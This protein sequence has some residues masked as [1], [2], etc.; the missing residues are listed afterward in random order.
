MSVYITSLGAFLPGNP[1]SNEEMEEYLGKIHGISSRSRERILKQN[2]IKT[3]YYAIDKT[4]TS[5]FSNSQMAANAATQA[6]ARSALLKEDVEL[7]VAATSQGDHPLPGFASMI[8]GELKIPRCEIA[9]VHGICASSV[10]GLKTAMLHLKAGEKSNALVCAAE[11][12]SRLFKASRF[13][14]QKSYLEPGSLPFESEFLRWMLSDG[15]GAAVLSNSPG[16]G[17][18]LKIE[19]IDIV[20][21]AGQFP[22]CMFV[23]PERDKDGN[24]PQSWLDYPSYQEAADAGAIN[25]R[26][27]VRMLDSVVQCGVEG[28]IEL[29]K[30]GR[31]DPFGID[32][33]VAHYSSSVFQDAAFNKGVELGVTIPRERWFSNLTTKGNVGAAS[34]FVLLEELLYSGKLKAGQQ[35]LCMV[36]ESGRYLFGYLLLTVV[37]P[38]EKKEPLPVQAFNA[39]KSAPP[40]LDAP[41]DP[42]TQRL[43]LELG[44]VWVELE[45]KL[46]DVPIIKKL[47]QGTF[48]LN[49]YRTLLLNLRQQV[50]D[51]S[52]WISRA[53]SSVTAEYFPIRAAF[54]AHTHDEHR[55][56]EML[57]RNYYS[58]GGSAEL[59]RTREKNVGSEALSAYILHKASQD[60]PFD[61]FGA[62]FIVEGLGQRTAKR[63]GELI[64]DCLK[65][66]DD[67]VSFFLYHSES[68]VIHFKR[69]ELVL[70]MGVLNEKLVR[71]IVRTARVVARLYVLQLEEL[72]A[73]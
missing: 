43:V 22:P 71:D 12:P 53:A 65:L 44:R 55:D 19:W 36:P 46:K 73:E 68:D 8:Q 1:V 26:Q 61:L 28:V 32:W 63:W 16:K 62:M 38:I 47:Y 59:M 2:G 66:E 39:S 56:Y 18:S 49:D 15:A 52:R 57:E 50:I 6:L 29:A 21:R 51:G 34:L 41:N 17:L 48:D 10:V 4:Q 72:E 67:Q 54:I 35:I 58:V 24:I 23:G 9:S 30:A 25:L 3:R 14:A 37:E 33:L 7:L 5:L 42:L 70:K 20:S 69:L 60:N 31:F 27:D 11:F 45:S 64:R 40:A 13:E